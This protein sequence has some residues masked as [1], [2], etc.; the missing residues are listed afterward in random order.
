VIR[1]PTHL[2]SLKK[3]PWT[4]VLIVALGL[5]LLGVPEH[6]EGPTLFDIPDDFAGPSP[7]HT[8]TRHGFTVANAFATVT[9]AAGSLLLGA[10]TWRNRGAV[11]SSVRSR[12]LVVALLLAQLLVGVVLI[13]VSGTSTAL[14]WWAPGT[15]V[16]VLALLGLASLIWA[17][18]HS[19][20]V[21]SV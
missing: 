9:L 13:L 8:G 3:W 11:A 4:G 1:F 18:L 6:H 16:C 7:I 5:V 20:E 17:T 12:P 21:A 2:R 10:G 14:L 19:A 15:I